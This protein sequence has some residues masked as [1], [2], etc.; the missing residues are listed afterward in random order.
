M[1]RRKQMPREPVE[2]FVEAS[3]AWT[4]AMD[5]GDSKTANRIHDRDLVPS[6]REVMT[7]GPEQVQRIVDLV[8]H[9]DPGVAH[10][11]AVFALRHDAPRAES[12]L[13]R[14]MGDPSWHLSFSAEWCLR[15]WREGSLEFAWEQTA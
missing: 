7:A 3:I 13:E 15:E 11:A 5:K 10:M 14:L 12:A 9:P 4:N 1:T 6:L 2:R 8:D